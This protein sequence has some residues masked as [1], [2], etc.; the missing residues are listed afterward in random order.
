MSP[1]K[2]R[3]RGSS[4][5][6]LLVSMSLLGSIMTVVLPMGIKVSRVRQLHQERLVVSESL[7]NEMDRLTQLAYERLQPLEGQLPLPDHL[8]AQLDQGHVTLELTD[9]TPAVRVTLTV[10]WTDHMG[11]DARLMTLC[12]WIYP[13]EVTP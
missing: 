4:I 11:N 12:G 9:E 6:E 1:R 2:S 13:Q 3:F 7:A 5:T 8:K 10:A